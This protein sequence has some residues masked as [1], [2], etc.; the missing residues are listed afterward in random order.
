MENV[1]APRLTILGHPQRLAVFRLLMRRHPDKVP[2]GELAEAL[3]LKA[4]TLSAYLAA[5]TQAG[6]LTQHR[7]GTSLRYGIAIE[8]VRDMF[9]YLL[10]DCC[11]GRPDLCAPA[12]S[13]SDTG[14]GRDPRGPFN[15]LFLCTGNSARSIFAEALLRDLGAGRFNAYSAGTQP[16]A[17][18][19]SFAVDLLQAKGHDVGL[20]RSKSVS[21]FGHPD[22]PRM[23]FVFTVCDQAAN[24][25][26][27][28]WPGQPVTG[29][30]GISDPAKATGTEAER[31]LV[32]QRAYGSLLRLISTFTALPLESLDRLA[33]QHAV[34]DIALHR[35]KDT[36]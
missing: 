28:A 1:I 29:H 36:Q 12:V 3:S 9:D 26:C 23:D 13:A 32:F 10:L 22:A 18:P 15:V 35:T 7:E 16:Q 21:E 33:R 20:L 24:E 2:A 25:E 4:S 6:L 19:N 5:L 27:P 31:A 17:A 30:W 11:R 34:D 14:E 8:A